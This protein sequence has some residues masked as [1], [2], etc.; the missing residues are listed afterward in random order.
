MKLSRP[1]LIGLLVLAANA[2]TLAV[3]SAPANLQAVVSG[4]TV[5]FTWT[6]SPG[7]AGYQLEAGS[8][9]GLSN[10]ASITLAPTST[11]SVPNVP[12]G[13]YFV[14]VRAVDGSGVSGPSNEV[15]VVVGGG[16]GGPCVSPP[17][18][19][20]R[21]RAV[22]D[23]TQVSLSW[24][25]AVAGCPPT[26]YIIRA[27]SHE[28]AYNLAQIPV[29]TAGFSGV[30]PDG[31]YFVDV[32]AVNQFGMSSTSGSIVVVVAAANQGGRVG[33]NTTTPAIVA[34]EQG[35]AV[36]IAEVVNRS[37]VPG[38][39]I[40]VSAALRNSGGVLTPAG[41]TFVRGQPR[42]LSATGVIDDSALAPG[43]IGCIYLPTS[44]PASVVAGANL[45]IAHE[46]FASSPMR[47]RVDVVDFDRVGTSGAAT[48][49]VTAVNAGGERSFFNLANLY[50][51]RSDGRAIG[52][53]FTFVPTADASLAPGQVSNF[54]AVTHAPESASTAVAW[55]H[56]QEAGDPLA[57]LAAQTYELMR[58]SVASPVEKRQALAAWNALQQQRRALA[59]QAGH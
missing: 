5:S 10:L 3:P 12:A 7:A 35:N 16:S 43:E 4:A 18:A 26:N 59:R 21:L 42:R 28:G 17:D 38:V 14:R 15:T 40:E 34:D 41:T 36:V 24:V 49:A 53:D 19:P 45:Q 46:S 55:M 9:A 32:V 52:C 22:V 8:A 56:W 51:K 1:G 29:P 57:G 58:R 47:T 44:I 6:G 2:V 20:T 39:F 11:Y 30:A 54:T 33:F 50:L 25:P 31:I 23:G 48:R 37:L 13:V 27:G